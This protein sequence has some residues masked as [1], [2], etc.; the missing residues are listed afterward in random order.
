[1][2]N[3][4]RAFYRATVRRGLGCHS[5]IAASPDVIPDAR[6]KARV[7][8]RHCPACA[9]C[10]CRRD[11]TRTN[12]RIAQTARRYGRPE[13][14]DDQLSAG[15][16]LSRPPAGFIGPADRGVASVAEGFRTT[17]VTDS[18]PTAPPASEAITCPSGSPGNFLYQGPKNCQRRNVSLVFLS[19]GCTS[20]I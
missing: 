4:R 11:R 19:T 3:G 20:V 12:A 17:E 15:Y 6:R 16:S 5:P 2:D 1:M 13:A 9:E 7:A 14:A 18:C 10:S 8:L